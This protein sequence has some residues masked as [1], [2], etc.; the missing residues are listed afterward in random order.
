MPNGMVLEGGAFGRCL[1]HEGVALVNGISALI[2]EA[3]L[4]SLATRTI[5]GP[6]KKALVMNQEEG[7]QKNA[8]MLTTWSWT[9]QN[10]QNW[11]K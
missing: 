9:S 1:G 10:I 4:S 5:W 8:T 2:K 3:P 11:E 6:S 7:P